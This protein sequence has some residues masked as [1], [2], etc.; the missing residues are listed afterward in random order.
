M[1]FALTFD[2][3]L[4][5]P[6]ASDVVPSEV[7]TL[8]KFSRNIK[9]NIP[10]VSAAMDTV[11]EGN[12][13]IALARLGGI[14]VVHRNLDMETQVEEVVRVKKFESGMVTNPV[15]VHPNETL[16]DAITLTQKHGISGILVVEKGILVGVLTRRDMRMIEDKSKKV[17]SLMTKNPITI[18]QNATRKEVRKIL[19]DN[20]IEKLPVVNSKGQCVGL[21]TLK[22]MEKEESNPLSSKDKVGR[23][24]VA[25]A[26]GTGKEEITRAEALIASE[27]DAL[28]VDTAHGHSSQVLKAVKQI[29]R[30]GN[31]FDIIAGNVATADASASL[32]SSGVD[33][34]KVGIGPGSICTTR[35]VAGVGVPQFTAVVDSA[36]V[37]N[38]KKIPL[39]A[40]G[41]IRYSGDVAKALAAGASCA[42]VGSLL[43]GTDES[44]GD[45]FLYQGRAYKAYRG[46]GSL[47]A[48]AQGSASR[49]FQTDNSKFVPEGVEGRVPYKGSVSALIYQLVG[50]LRSAMGYVGA[51][52]LI[53]LQKKANF[54][55]IS[56]AGLRE[57][58]VHDVS[59]TREAPNYPPLK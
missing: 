37:C 53:E 48:M 47:A 6:G 12:M 7:A 22:D 54:C 59:I 27:V 17:A 50:G 4:I 38:R 33:G 40:D 18:K 30:L 8:S 51:K 41:G 29:R 42:M 32:I 13:A 43:A 34:V 19:F 24:R 23:L 36:K 39:I 20:K 16:G 46:M 52:N 49:Y 9:L 5:K 2:D 10:L 3:V 35:V 25:A 44:P 56:P 14:G 1:E 57:N 31:S 15:S 11:T 58:H 45:V 28:V 26:I 55:R 21:F